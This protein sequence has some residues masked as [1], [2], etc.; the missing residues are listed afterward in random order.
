MATDSI[1][2]YYRIL[3][4][5]PTSTLEEIKRAYRNKAKELHPDRNK[6]PDAHEQFI[7]LT[8]AYEYLLNLK[9]GKT[10]AKQP[11]VSYA[12]WQAQK[13]EQARQRARQYAKMKHEEFLKSDYYKGFT[14]IETVFNHL[15][16]VLAIAILIVLPI[17]AI[18][19]HGTLGFLWSLAIMVL[20]S[21]I[22]VPA[23]RNYSRLNLNTFFSAFAYLTGIKAFQATALTILNVFLFFRIGLQTLISFHLI[24][25]IIIS[26]IL[27]S[28]A[29]TKWI[30]KT[31]SGRQL[32]ISLCLI[33]LAINFA[34][35]VNYIFS[36][37]PTTERYHF[38][39]T[40]ERTRRGFQKTT[41]IL[42]DDNKYSEFPGIRLFLDYEA[43]MG[44]FQITY[45]FKDGL[46]GPRVM[47]DYKFERGY[48]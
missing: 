12:D 11:T 5:T 1:D 17:M 40:K 32:F 18:I 43:M 9:A 8:E 35:T 46:L 19:L 15:G 38:T 25:A 44:S 45:T 23:I 7:L 14:A 26:L 39:N 24:S 37:N 6:S 41:F 31:D 22:T 36:S 29:I 34:L 3:H 10:R 33:P 47:T 16:F 4:V 27:I 30:T 42:L 2:N 21:Q 20:S 13:R 28:F 48:R